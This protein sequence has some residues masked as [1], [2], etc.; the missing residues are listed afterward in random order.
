LGSYVDVT[1]RSLRKEKVDNSRFK[2]DSKCR[3]LL[4]Y[5]SCMGG[6]KAVYKA[7]LVGDESAEAKT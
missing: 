4:R 1:D 3:V 6:E 7:N 5:P 2:V